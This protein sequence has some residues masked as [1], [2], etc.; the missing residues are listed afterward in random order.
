MG[1]K[2]PYK[3]FVKI[4]H[5]RNEKKNWKYTK[6]KPIWLKRLI[7]DKTTRNISN[8][9]PKNQQDDKVNKYE[10][11]DENPPT[12]R[13]HIFLIVKHVGFVSG[14]YDVLTLSLFA[15]WFQVEI[16]FGKQHAKI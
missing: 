15:L 3:I 9:F 12:Q 14:A 6:T 2:K 4:L 1:N 11:Q 16:L 8:I 13:F 5:F 10:N 7:F